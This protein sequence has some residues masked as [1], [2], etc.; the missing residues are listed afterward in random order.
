ML[1][2]LEA[3]FKM[4]LEIVDDTALILLYLQL[5]RYNQIYIYRTYKNAFKP[6]RQSVKKNSSFF[7]FQTSLMYLL[8]KVP[9]VAGYISKII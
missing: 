6:Y 7:V 4:F 5:I 2:F 1:T 9:G 3:L 8:K